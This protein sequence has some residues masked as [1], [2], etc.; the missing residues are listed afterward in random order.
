MKPCMLVQWFRTHWNFN[1]MVYGSR[2]VSEE[3]KLCLTLILFVSSQVYNFVPALL[4]N[5]LRKPNE[6]LEATPGHNGSASH[7]SAK[8][9]V[10]CFSA[11][12]RLCTDHIAYKEHTS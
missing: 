9:N 6:M 11:V 4:T 10:F 7:Q 2:L 1:L 3:K 5:I 8:E 12:V